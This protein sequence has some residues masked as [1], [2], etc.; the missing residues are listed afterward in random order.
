MPVYNYMIESNEPNNFTKYEI[1]INDVLV[2]NIFGK[3]DIVLTR[4]ECF[5]KC[6][7]KLYIINNA[8]YGSRYDLIFG[9]SLAYSGIISNDS[10]FPCNIKYPIPLHLLTHCVLTIVIRNVNTKLLEHN[11]TLVLHHYES[12][13]NTDLV[14]DN[15]TFSNTIN[16]VWPPYVAE[17][18]KINIIRFISGHVGTSNNYLFYDKKY[19]DNN[20][21]IKEVGSYKVMNVCHLDNLNCYNVE[22]KIYCDEYYNNRLYSL[23]GLNDIN[24]F[25][26]TL[27]IKLPK[28]NL[29]S[30]ECNLV[31]RDTC[32][33]VTNL[34]FLTNNIIN[35]V[36]VNNS[37]IPLIKTTFGYK[38]TICSD[39]LHLV[40]VSRYVD[41]FVI[42]VECQD[43]E[44]NSD[45]YLKYD[46]VLYDASIRRKI[47]IGAKSFNDNKSIQVANIKNI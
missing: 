2:E 34:E 9:S 18:N 10:I 41:E 17:D 8:L 43:N 16:I 30:Y 4:H 24:V 12:D 45:I 26:E 27:K 37:E 31:L 5:T 33:A 42:F 29:N 25:S 36:K 11:N 28:V 1:K 15:E 6:T 46:R 40:L 32:D 39:E 14:V 19:L 3:N 23:M 44:D 38:I 22:A 21:F 35:S 7:Q 20:S 13:E 47:T